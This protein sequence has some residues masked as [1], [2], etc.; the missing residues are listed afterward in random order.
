MKKL[1]PII[2][3]ITIILTS[4]GGGAASSKSMEGSW[5]MDEDSYITVEGNRAVVEMSGYSYAGDISDGEI[6]FKKWFT[7]KNQTFTI[8][9]IGDKLVMTE[10]D[11]RA[12]TFTKDQAE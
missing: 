4:C 5:T 2:L 3:A 12:Y 8:E 7:R 10:P 1:V 11:G 9:V 6:T